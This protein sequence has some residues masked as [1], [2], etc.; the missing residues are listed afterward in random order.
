MIEKIDI[1]LN[2]ME[3]V[4]KKTSSIDED[5]DEYLRKKIGI[6]SKRERMKKIEEL[7]TLLIEGGIIDG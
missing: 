5:L 4:E 2:E 3:I 7:K 6:K 1:Y